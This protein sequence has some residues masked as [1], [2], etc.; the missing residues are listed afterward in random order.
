MDESLLKSNFI[1]RDGFRWWVGQIPPEKF[2]GG[3]I[4]GA[5][6]GNRHKVR[7]MGY[8]PYNTEELSNEDLPWAQCLLPTTSGTGAAN[9]ASSTKISPGDIV[10]GFFLDGDNGQIP[11]IMGCFG[12]TDQ[13]PDTE[14]SGPFQPFTGYT[15]KIKKPNGTLIPDQSNQNNADAQ[16]SPRHVSPEQAKNLDKDEISYYGAIGDKIQLAN[17]VGSTVINKISTEVSNLVNRL[18]VPNIFTN[19]KNEIN[20]VVDKIQAITNGLVGSMMN[21]LFKSMI[22]IFKGGLGL[23]YKSVFAKV[24]ATGVGAPAAALAGIAAQKALAIPMKA[25]QDAL[26]CVAGSVVNDLGNIIKDMLNS[27]IDNVENFVTCAANQFVGVLVND[28]IGKITTGLGSVL[29]GIQTILELLPGFSIDNLLRAGSDAIK[30]VV[31][32]FDCNQS[33][34]KGQGLV[35]EWIIGRGPVNAPGPDFNK[36]LENAN[37]T[38]A[39]ST[40]GNIFNEVQDIIGGVNE[41]TAGVT[42]AFSAINNIPRKVDGCYTGPRLYCGAPTIS[43]FG[44]GGSGA[45]GISLIGGISG[46]SGSVIGVKLT[47]G[48]SGYRF[49]PFVEISDNCNQ[50]YGAIG[51]AIIDYDETS[52]TYGQ[53]T[54]VYIV[55]EGENYP[56]GDL[57]D[58][59]DNTTADTVIADNSKKEPDPFVPK[60]YVVPNVI[61]VDPGNGYEDTDKAKDQFNNDYSIEIDNGKIIKIQIINII[62]GIDNIVTVTDLPIITISSNTGS[63]AILKPIL[64]FEPVEFQG[65][66]K[67]VIDCVK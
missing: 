32:I 42:G 54:E 1:G 64:D 40:A 37:I 43:I 60:I 36:I 29:G 27:V 11:V 49:P 47:N 2:H 45:T 8:H 59:S 57:Y 28:I 23:L 39:I 24:L 18:K 20:R 31:G 52:P 62:N 10:F 35:D 15:S 33:K 30:G 51:R 58:D 9:Q 6:W 55:S 38:N 26:S 5:G 41:V 67:Q 21:G 25:V 66:V 22:P 3:Q 61:I 13:V 50:G 4:N 48:G 56:I 65:E 12:R 16:K 14:A 46:I 19:I 7:I 44:G 34:S 63:G 53:V 17:T